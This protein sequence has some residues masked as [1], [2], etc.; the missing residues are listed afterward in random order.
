MTLISF[1]LKTFHFSQTYQTAAPRSSV[2]FTIHSVTDHSLEKQDP[3]FPKITLQKGPSCYI[4][5]SH[6]SHGLVTYTPEVC[7]PTQRN[8]TE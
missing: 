8:K 6:Q 4:N 2:R 1:I 3:V 7:Y 5:V